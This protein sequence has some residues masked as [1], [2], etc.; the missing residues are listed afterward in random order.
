MLQIIGWLLCAYLVV[1]AFE[2]FGHAQN[3]QMNKTLYL[4][5]GFL[6]LICAPV[7]I[8]MLNAQAENSSSG[9]PNF[10][11]NSGLFSGDSSTLDDGEEATLLNLQAEAAADSNAAL[12]ATDDL[13]AAAD[14]ALRE[15][16]ESL[17][18]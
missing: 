13:G 14:N 1:K 2:Q 18:R 15:A 9:M 7:F 11:A 5:S 10:S 17:R 16:E 6:S 12:A 4:V 3:A 8:M